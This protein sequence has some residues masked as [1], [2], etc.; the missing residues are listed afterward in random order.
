MCYL[1]PIE[2]KGSVLETMTC[3][4]ENNDEPSCPK[5]GNYNAMLWCRGGLR[6]EPEVRKCRDCGQE[7][8]LVR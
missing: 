3:S 5:C 6:N 1:L 4:Y 8:T 2:R 7:A